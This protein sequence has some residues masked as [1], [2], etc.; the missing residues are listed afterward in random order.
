MQGFGGSNCSKHDEKVVLPMFHF[1]VKKAVWNYFHILTVANDPIEIMTSRY[2][3][4]RD[5]VMAYL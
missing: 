4:I 2:N 3:Q 5:K 1:S